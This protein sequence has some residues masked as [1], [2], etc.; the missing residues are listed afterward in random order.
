MM[1]NELDTFLV[2]DINSIGIV[3]IERWVEGPMMM[4]WKGWVGLEWDSALW[5]VDPIEIGN[6]KWIRGSA[7]CG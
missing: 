4:N 7:L 2:G 6:S 1:G 3:G 5:F